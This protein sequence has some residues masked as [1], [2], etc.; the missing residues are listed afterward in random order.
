VKFLSDCLQVLHRGQLRRI[1]EPYAHHSMAVA[2][3]FRPVRPDDLIGL[4]KR[5]LQD[6]VGETTGFLKPGVMMIVDALTKTPVAS[7]QRRRNSI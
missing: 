1:C 2:W 4:G 7:V 5:F 3:I 6:V